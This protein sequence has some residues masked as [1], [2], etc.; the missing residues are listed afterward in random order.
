MDFILKKDLALGI[1]TFW[2]GDH[3]VVEMNTLES[4][5]FYTKKRSSTRYFHLLGR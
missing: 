3:F 1:F 2:E 5:G 4:S